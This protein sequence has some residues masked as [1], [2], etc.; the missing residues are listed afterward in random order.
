MLKAYEKRRLRNFIFS[1]SSLL[2]LIVAVAIVA[3]GV[4]DVYQQQRMTAGKRAEEE[5]K[6]SELKEREEVLRTEIERLDTRVGLEAELR[7]KYEVGHQGE[8]LI[9]IVDPKEGEQVSSV[10]QSESLWEGIVRWFKRD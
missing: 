2:V 4:W 9:V 3:V 5:R 8:G 6:L 1:K 10:S 7:N